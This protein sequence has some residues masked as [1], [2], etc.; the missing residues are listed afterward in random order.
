MSFLCG[1]GGDAGGVWESSPCPSLAL[2]E[3]RVGKETQRNPSAQR[4]VCL[5][6]GS[7]PSPPCKGTNWE[8]KDP[9]G[10][11]PQP[12]WRRGP[13]D[14]ELAIQQSGAATDQAWGHRV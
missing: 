7:R 5:Q 3:L 11:R 2:A 1:G 13:A 10:H 8:H 6:R 9:P 12:G 4:P 14:L